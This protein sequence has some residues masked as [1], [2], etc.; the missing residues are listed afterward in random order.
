MLP[1][2][3]LICL[4]LLLA[5]PA[6]AVPG[7]GARR[8]AQLGPDLPDPH[9][10]R[11]ASGAPGP[12][13]WQQQADHRIEVELIDGPQPVVVGRGRIT[14]HNR[15]PHSLDYLWLQLEQNRFRR[16]A[17][18]WLAETAP[19]FERF[20][21]RELLRILAMEDFEGGYQ[22]SDVKLDGRPAKSS[23][24]YT[25]MRIDLPK[26]LAPGGKTEIDLGWRYNVV[27]A[28]VIGARGG[29]ELLEDGSRIFTLAQWFP[30]MAAYTDY[31]GWQHKQ[32][33]GRGEFT[34]EFGDFDVKIT[35]PADHVVTATGELQNPE[36]VLTKTQ[37][38][39]LARAAK[40][41]SPQ[42]I[43]TLEEATAAMNAAPAPGKKTWHFKAENVR[44]FAFAS[45]RSFLWDAMGVKLPESGR[46]ALAM[47]LYPPHA[48]PLWSRFSTQAVAHTLEVYSRMTF[49]YPYP[50]A[51]SVNGAVGGMEYPMICFNGPRAE[52]D[53]TYYD[54]AGEGKRWKY[55]KYGL[56][57]VVIHEVGHNWFPMIINSDERQWTWLDEGLNT[58]LQFVAEQ[59]WEAEYPSRRGHPQSIAEYMKSPEQV[60]IMNN[61]ESLLQFGNNAYA[62]PT[63][64]LNILRETILGRELFDFAFKTY[65]R[66]WRFKRP[67][68]ADFFRTME[69]ASG[70]DLDWFWRGWFYTTDHVDIALVDVR[71][72]ELDTRNPSIEKPKE[73]KKEDEDYLSIT[74]ERNEALREPMRLDRFPELRDFYDTFD[75]HAVTVQDREQFEEL[76]AEL[77]PDERTALET[78]RRFYVVDF[79]NQGGL[80][81]PIILRITYEGGDREVLRLPAEIW[82]LDA[83]KVSKLFVTKKAIT[84]V[85]VD[86]FL[87]TA[88]ADVAD[89]AWPR[90]PVKTKFQLFKEKRQ[91]NAMQAEAEAKK[92]AE[93]KAPGKVPESKPNPEAPPAAPASAPASAP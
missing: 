26:P 64:A 49:D 50:V 88:D 9:E 65:A 75:P 81:M 20:G 13:Y 91:N 66:R 12:A 90:V 60:P 45:A 44:D 38:E 86:P 4:C 25:M 29:Y 54:R 83:D 37:R 72:Y 55:S 6:F 33:L 15:S 39:R 80:V 1:G 3:R 24:V 22:I 36:A 7:S 79:E 53:G 93:E 67:E 77:E 8:F 23:V 27:N 30:R 87:E 63:A 71:E 68:P 89:N 19:A 17:L 85:E 70:M 43:I 35:V 14:Y 32:F 18:G 2:M 76:L 52:K 57:G 34:L 21:Y 58:F 84:Q 41:A 48:A 40:A 82:K 92:K 47:S 10:G 59:S 5:L 46:T 51:I 31:Q 56:I 69:D 16:D 28:D 73:R 61:S 62:K 78:Q 42:F 11:L 74:R